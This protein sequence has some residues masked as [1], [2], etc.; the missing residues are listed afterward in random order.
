MIRENE[1]RPAKD[2]IWQERDGDLCVVLTI[3]I[4][5]IPIAGNQEFVVC[6]SEGGDARLLPLNE[7]RHRFTP[8]G[9]NPQ[10]RPA[11][12]STCKAPLERTLAFENFLVRI[13][14]QSSIP[15]LIG[16]P[17][18]TDRSPRELSADQALVYAQG[19]NDC[20]QCVHAPE[21]MN[22]R[23]RAAALREVASICDEME[24]IG[25]AYCD[26]AQLNG[27]MDLA[28]AAG[29]EPRAYN[30]LASK[31]RAMSEDRLVLPPFEDRA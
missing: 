7:W 1:T 8:V 14:S 28:L 9:E 5:E 23:I 24:E 11:L 15:L 4:L 20:A 6:Q 16:E 18:A 13:G 17:A 10:L 29:G 26:T 3:A 22:R 2:S 31:L 12:P 30:F 21:Q 25:A 19:W 27:D